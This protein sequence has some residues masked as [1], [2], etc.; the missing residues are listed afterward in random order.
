VRDG[1]PAAEQGLQP[2]DV[3]E[4]ID[5]HTVATP[6]QVKEDLEQQAHAGKKTALL[7]VERQNNDMFVGLNLATS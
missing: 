3:I 2:G 4:K 6:K 5:G 1:G 7:L